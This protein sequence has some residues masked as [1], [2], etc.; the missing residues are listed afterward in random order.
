MVCFNEVAVPMLGIV[1]GGRLGKG[2][3]G[4]GGVPRR[5][6]VSWERGV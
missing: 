6:C 3:R 5:R 4:G 1:D 2:G